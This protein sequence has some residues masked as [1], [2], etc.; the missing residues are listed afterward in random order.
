MSDGDIL[1]YR[2]WYENSAGDIIRLDEAPILVQ[3]SELLD[4]RWNLTA[5]DRALRD[6][7]KVIHAR[8][9]IQEKSLVLDVF[10]DTQEEH[11]AALN[12][13]HDVMDYDVCA[14]TPGKLWVN[15]RYIRC[16]VSAS[17]KTLD[18]NWTTYT[19]VGLTVKVIS[20]AWMAE[21]KVTLLPISDV[22]TDNG[23]KA[24][25]NRYPYRYSE[26]GNICRWI[27]TTG[28]PAPMVIKIFG[29]CS[30]PSV[31]VGENEYS[32]SGDIAAG[33][34]AVIDQRDKS[35]YTVAA[36]GTKTNI[37]GRRKKSVD[38][39]LYAPPGNLQISCSGLFAVE[40]T[41]MTQRSEPEARSSAALR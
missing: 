30:S 29:A 11:D 28:S 3:R 24:Y 7:G 17:V 41:F 22:Q 37:F 36:N 16:F 23:A 13:L 27:N 35:I 19:V 8:R 10:A 39:F 6:G 9:P 5:Y 4:Y 31:Y 40:I 12:R 15:D 33:S 14:L 21:E 26:G 38:N 32:V 1:P 25:P 2:V 34:Y 18:R 20:P